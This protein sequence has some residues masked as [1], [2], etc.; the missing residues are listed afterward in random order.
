MR[1][2]PVQSYFFAKEYK[3][4]NVKNSARANGI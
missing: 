2:K 1:T 4:I 3:F